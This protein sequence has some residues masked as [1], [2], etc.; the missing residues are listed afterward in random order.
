[1]GARLWVRPAAIAAVGVLLLGL[2]G[3]GDETTAQPAADPTR[4][5]GPVGEWASTSISEDPPAARP[6]VQ[7]PRI[8]LQFLDDGRVLVSGGC[9]GLQG[10][11]RIDEGQFAISDSGSTA[12]GCMDQSLHRMDEW[13]SAFFAAPRAY[14]YDGSRIELS[15]D[16]TRVVLRPLKEVEPD[17]PLEGTRWE[18]THLTQGSVGGGAADTGAAMAPPP[19]AFLVIRA[20]EFTADDGCNEFTGRASVTGDSV[21]FDPGVTTDKACPDGSGTERIRAVLE[22]TVHWEINRGHLS[23]EHPSGAGLALRAASS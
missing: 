6:L 2:G 15:S 23:L 21:R 12:V 16:T 17:L 9:N 11:L 1:M 3:C 20:G 22:G 14:G 19:G 8:Y 10:S 7:P 18:I 13:I 5:A 4:A